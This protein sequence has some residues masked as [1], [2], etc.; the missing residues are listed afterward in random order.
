MMNGAFCA[1]PVHACANA[2]YAC[3]ALPALP[4]VPAVPALQ[5]QHD[6]HA[7]MQ[8][9]SFT[10][11]MASSKRSVMNPSG[12][13]ELLASSSCPPDWKGVDLPHVSYQEVLVAV[14]HRMAPWDSAD[15]Y[16]PLLCHR[17]LPTPPC[18][19]ALAH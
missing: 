9:G 4:A 3:P 2:C 18:M 14:A 6:V 13:K 5:N 12:W 15:G 7:T 1:D 11:K 10:E 17:S 8:T 16:V 19:H